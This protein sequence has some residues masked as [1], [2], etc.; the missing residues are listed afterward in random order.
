MTLGEYK[1]LEVEKKVV[2]IMAT[3]VNAE[4]EKVRE[5]NSR[6]VTV[7]NRGIKKDD[8]AVIDFEGFVDGEALREEREKIIRW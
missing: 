2:K 7:D 4:L 3:D 1:G 8:T 6:M 5:Q